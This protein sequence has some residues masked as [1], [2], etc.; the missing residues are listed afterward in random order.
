MTPGGQR[1][2]A[3][4]G[5]AVVWAAVW[6]IW[7]LV[8]RVEAGDPVLRR[9]TLMPLWSPQ[10]QFAGHYVAIDR[11]I[12]A[13]HGLEVEILRSG[14]GVSPPEALAHG[15]ADFAVLWLTTA[16]QQRDRG[17]PIVHVAQIVQ[18]SAL[19]LVSR[20]SSGI[21]SPADMAGRKVGMWG[22]D[23]SIPVRALFVRHGVDVREVPQA[24]TINL[25]LR[26]GIEVASAMWY[27]EYHTL[28][29]SGVEAD[30]LGVLFLGEQGL[31]FPED[32]LYALEG[33]V[34]RD[35]AMVA[36]FRAATLEGWRMA[37][38]KPDLALDSVLRR[39]RDA[40]IPANRVHQ[41]W[42]LSRMEDLMEPSEPSGRPGGLGGAD[43]ESVAAAMV[44]LGLIREV[45]DPSV[46]LWRSHAAVE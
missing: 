38:G 10:A 33:T 1:R 9:V 42:M 40:R 32:G 34:R 18:R 39:M 31:N 43:C 26:G 25:F 2:V 19:L 12:Y 16:L 17:I 29:S 46:F 7:L 11:G 8:C 37:F 13:R 23:L 3:A 21:R 30:D 41:R 35:P 14:P 28:L 6:L 15:S 36:A 4:V 22:G 24:H 27:N 20:K 45:P 5:R 44:G